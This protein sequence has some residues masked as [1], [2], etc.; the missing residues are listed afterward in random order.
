MPTGTET[1]WGDIAIS[2]VIGDDV[3]EVTVESEEVACIGSG[4]EG[5]MLTTLVLV[6]TV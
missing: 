2:E 5:V 1:V 6:S 3:V 4:E